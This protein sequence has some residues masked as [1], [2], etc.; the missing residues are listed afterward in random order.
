MRSRSTM[1]YLPCGFMSAMCGTRA[2][3]AVE[4]VELELDP[5]LVRDRE[6]VQHRVRGAAERHPD[7]DRVL[8]R[9]LRHDLAGPDVRARAGCMTA[10]PLSNAKSSRRR[11]T[12]GGDE[13]PGQRHAERLGDRRHRVGGEHARR[14]SPRSGTPAARSRPARSRVMRAGG[15]RADRLEHADDVER[16]VLV[17]ARAGSTRRRGTPTAG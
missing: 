6:Q 14:T 7:R 4:V 2:P 8:E 1:W 10:S 5:G 11:S 3:I 13:L 17:V 15:A 12:A 16:L 9:L